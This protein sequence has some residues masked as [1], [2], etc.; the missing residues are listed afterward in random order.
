MA[1]VDTTICVPN[2]A[3]LATESLQEYCPVAKVAA[4]TATNNA[5]T[6]THFTTRGSDIITVVRYRYRPARARL[7]FDEKISL[8][9]C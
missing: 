8:L 9:F 4:A 5:A 7:R 2:N 6:G 1:L 3:S